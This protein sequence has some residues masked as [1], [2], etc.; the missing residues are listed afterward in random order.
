V[1]S[2]RR[3]RSAISDR[4]ERSAI[5]ASDQRS[6]RAISD[7]RERAAIGVSE[8]LAGGLGEWCAHVEC[9]RRP[10]TLIADRSR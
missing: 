4:R 7:R 2:D 9:S 10:F 6:A 3:E 8:Q 1:I 5:G